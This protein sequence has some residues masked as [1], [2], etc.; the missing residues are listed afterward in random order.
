MNPLNRGNTRFLLSCLFAIILVLTIGAGTIPQIEAE[1]YGIRLDNTCKTM[2]VN[3]IT[4]NCPSYEDIITLFPDT[5]NRKIT[6]EFGYYHG[7][8]QRLPTKLINSFEYYRF[9][10]TTI[11]FIDP[12]PNTN[13]RIRI[14]EI[15]ANL[16]EYKL[17][18]SGTYNP[19]DHSLTLGVGRYID[20]C[21]IAYV[22][23]ANWISYVGDTM[24]HMADNCSPESTTYIDRITTKLNRTVHDITTS[25]KYQLAKWQQESIE[26]CGHK[27]CIYE[28]NLPPPP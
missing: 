24:K 17:P 21:R 19:I 13:D 11:L 3:N 26:R 16:G 23:S 28:K 1:N 15:K 14:I 10:N 9:W 8:Y 4:S 7:I 22:D 12:P 5:S 20:S 25:Y 27:I 2:L 6:G 18:K